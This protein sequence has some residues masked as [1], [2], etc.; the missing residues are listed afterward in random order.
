VKIFNYIKGFNPKD[1]LSNIGA[2]MGLVGGLMLAN[3]QAGVLPSDRYEK[4][5]HGL[6]GSS[7]VLI[8]FATGKNKDLTGGQ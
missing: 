7:I 2:V 4:T 5:A 6:I 1:A 3:I 8:G